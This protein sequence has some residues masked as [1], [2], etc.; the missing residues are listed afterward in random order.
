MEQTRINEIIA[1]ENSAAIRQTEGL[2]PKFYEV[3]T[4]AFGNTV[5]ALSSHI[6]TRPQTEVIERE[7]TFG[8]LPSPA[9]KIVAREVLSGHPTPPLKVSEETIETE[10]LER[11][12]DT[13]T[14]HAIVEVTPKTAADKDEIRSTISAL[15]A[16]R[17]LIELGRSQRLQMEIGD[18]LIT[19]GNT[20]AV[21]H[22][23]RRGTFGNYRVERMDLATSA[24][25]ETAVAEFEKMTS[26]VLEFNSQE[27]PNSDTVAHEV[28]NQQIA[29]DIAKDKGPTKIAVPVLV[30]PKDFE[31]LDPK[32]RWREE[33]K[34]RYYYRRISYPL[35]KDA[36]PNEPFVSVNKEGVMS[37]EWKQQ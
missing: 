16:M 9:K 19:I 1:R 31:T 37:A 8:V 7:G 35:I 20:R 13:A 26:E 4:N 5:N 27:Q 2:D 3:F 15:S 10:K 28:I 12:I 18:L 25:F 30:Y 29:Q 21:L 14:L 33:G 11:P 22:L 23:I 36:L 17:K 6:P 24:D 32:N 34:D